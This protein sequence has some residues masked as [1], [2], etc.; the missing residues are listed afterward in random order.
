MKKALSLYFLAILV[1]LTTS[2]RS[3]GQ[4][5]WMQ[6]GFRRLRARQFHDAV[7]AFSRA[8][9]SDPNNAE[10]YN[11]R[12]VA[13]AYL[14]KIDQAIVDYT[15]ALAIKPDLVGALNNRGSAFYQKALLNQAISDYSKAIEINPYFAEAYSNRG[16]VW[17]AKGDYFRA[18]RDYTQALETNP[19]FDAP[20][21]NR[22][23]SLTLIGDYGQAVGDIQK[24]IELNPEFH[25][26]YELLAK[27][28][29]ECP[30]P[31]IK[32]AVKAVPFAEK[33]V[34]LNPDPEYL[35]TLAL[36]YTD[37]GNFDQAILAQQQALE[38][39]R[40]EGQTDRIG[41]Y[42]QGLAAIMEKKNYPPH[43]QTAALA[44]SEE[45]KVKPLQKT[46]SARKEIP[47]KKTVPERSL[48]KETMALSKK[49][50]SS[51]KTYTIQAGAFLSKEYAGERIR[52]LLNRGYNARLDRFTDRKGRTWHTVRIG[53]FEDLGGAR[54]VAATITAKEKIRTS[55]R[56]GD[57][58]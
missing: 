38:M 33:A 12:G 40:K 9:A 45:P 56:P 15:K 36:A 25:A 44:A 53:R 55:V 50:P 54:R 2:I 21:Y 24:A 11:H 7:T 23:R 1:I 13:W 30:D 57:S 26:A 14:G 3:R 32:D 20:Y 16:T 43:E 22:G 28:Y 42:E 4:E 6:I 46:V 41:A 29:I 34:R 47:Q 8:I 27:I 49:T 19:Y 5:D 51:K 31:E 58:L 52:F 18:I 48:K 17:A 39:L 35:G 37:A 10:A